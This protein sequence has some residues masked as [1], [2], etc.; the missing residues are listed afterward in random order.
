MTKKIA[1]IAILLITAG[2]I[3]GPFH[4][5]AQPGQADESEKWAGEPLLADLFIA[6]PLGLIQS[7]V[8]A[9]GFIVSIPVAVPLGST[10]T[11][12][13][14]LLHEPFSYTFQR[15]LGTY[16]DFYYE[17]EKNDPHISGGAQ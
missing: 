8:G 12:F 10:R 2:Q 4:G 6:R 1:F 13:E 7:I 16:D 14:L 11:A 15:P 5:Y 17:F 3:I 9:V